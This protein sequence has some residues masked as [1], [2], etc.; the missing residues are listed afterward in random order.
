MSV[1]RKRGSAALVHRT[2]F[3]GALDNDLSDKLNELHKETKIPKNRLYDEAIE[4][5]LNK[6]NKSY[7]A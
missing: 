7:N 1:P 2:P 5:L 3:S 4:L 6:Y